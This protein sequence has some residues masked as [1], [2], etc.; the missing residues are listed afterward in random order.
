MSVPS[1]VQVRALL[2][3]CAELQ[4]KPGIP[5]NFYTRRASD[6]LEKE[7]KPVLI[8]NATIWTG[9]SDGYEIVHG[10][11]ILEAGIIQWVG[12]ELT[13]EM[14]KRFG[15]DIVIV[16]ADGSYVTPG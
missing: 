9:E 5:A 13:A 8:R 2:T 15:D 10:D 14:S 16:D 12:G 11:I 1:T 6:R 4:S 7:T 3:R